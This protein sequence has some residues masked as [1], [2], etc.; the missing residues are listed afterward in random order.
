MRLPL[1]EI[2]LPI[3]PQT[4]SFKKLPQEPHRNHQSNAKRTTKKSSKATNTD[5][6]KTTPNLKVKKKAERIEGSEL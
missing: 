6:E 3:K 1:L 4:R 5:P 2:Y